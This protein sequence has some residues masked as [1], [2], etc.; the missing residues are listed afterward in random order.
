MSQTSS[1]RHILAAVDF[2]QATEGVFALSV[3]LARALNASLCLL[4]AGAPDPTFVG[5]EPGPQTVRDQVAAEFR[6][7][8]RRLHALQQQ[9]QQ[10]GVETTTRFVQGPAVDTILEEATNGGADLIVMGSHGHGP[11]RHLLLGSVSEGVLRK[12]GCPVLL[13]PSS[14]EKPS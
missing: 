13:A 1:I 9:A 7:Q 6:E 14:G 4:H 10:S 5:F 3:D 2:S 11:L 8:H 12:A